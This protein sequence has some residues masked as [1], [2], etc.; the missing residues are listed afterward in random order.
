MT[1][2]DISLMFFDNKNQALI[3][4]KIKKKRNFYMLIGLSAA[5]LLGTGG[6][7]QTIRHIEE[8]KNLSL[9][10]EK[11]SEQYASDIKKYTD[12]IEMKLLE[13]Q[14]AIQELLEKNNTPEM[15]A[16]IT[17]LSK[18]NM[19]Y[20]RDQIFDVKHA[21]F[22]LDSDRQVWNNL[23]QSLR[24][25]MWKKDEEKIEFIKEFN[26]KKMLQIENDF[27][28]SEKSDV[29]YQITMIDQKI[30]DMQNYF[31]AL[32][33]QKS[34]FTPEQYENLA[35]IM[36]KQAAEEQKMKELKEKYTPTDVDRQSVR[37]DMQSILTGL[38][39]QIMVN[40]FMKPK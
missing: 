36:T 8:Q 32:V 35:H 18:D 20:F 5:L 29:K 21:L 16:L 7:V 3:H 39:T 27:K 9:V 17:M 26:L 1:Q 19:S 2:Q 34:A 14:K 33:K 23:R 13:R 11:L 30:A 25:V 4:Q 10:Q 31:D 22:L 37:Q 6:I 15:K 24:E 12:A 38:T 40:Q 28:D